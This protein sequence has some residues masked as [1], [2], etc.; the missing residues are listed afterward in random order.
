MADGRPINNSPNRQR[1]RNEANAYNAA[2]GPFVPTD[3]ANG[4]PDLFNPAPQPGT[5]WAQG[6]VEYDFTQLVNAVYVDIRR[7][8]PLGHVPGLAAPQGRGIVQSDIW[9]ARR[10]ILNASLTLTQKVTRLRALAAAA[11][12]VVAEAR[13]SGVHK[14]AAAK[15][16]EAKRVA[17]KNKRNRRKR[18]GQSCRA[19]PHVR[20]GSPPKS[21]PPSAGRVAGRGA[22]FKLLAPVPAPAQA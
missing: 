12:T 6:H 11:A 17:A 7:V 4:Y 21:P 16:K 5:L 2:R 22:S 10:I 3:D 15:A 13:A 18:A 20:K 9:P 1:A 8:H 19:S 14:R